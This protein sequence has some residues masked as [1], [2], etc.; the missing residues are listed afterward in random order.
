MPSIAWLVTTTS[1]SRD[2]RLAPAR[3]STRRASGTCAPRHS[4]D[5]T[6][7]CRHA[8]SRDAGDEVVAVARS[9]VSSAHSRSRSDLLAERSRSARSRPAPGAGCSAAPGVLA[10]VE[11]RAR[12]RPSRVAARD[13]VHAEVVVPALE[14][15]DRAARAAGAARA[16]AATSG[17]S[18]VMIWRCSARVAV[19]TTTC[20]S[21]QHRVPHAR[22][23]GSRA[24]CRCRCRPGRA[25]ARPSSIGLARRRRA[26]CV[27]AVAADR[28]RARRPRGRGASSTRRGVGRRGTAVSLGRAGRTPDRVGARGRLGCRGRRAARPRDPRRPGRAAPCRRSV[29]S[30]SVDLARA[31]CTRLTRSPRSYGTTTSTVTPGRGS[32]SAMSA[33]SSSMPSPVCAETTI[34]CTSRERRR[35]IASGVGE[36]GLVEHDDLGHVHRRPG[37]PRSTCRTAAICPSGS[38]C[39]AST[40]CSIRSASATSSSVERN[41]ST[42]WCGR[43]R[44]KP[45]VSASV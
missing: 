39:D 36:V 32:W 45:T 3:G 2:A 18:R 10:E 33:C 11:Q 44:T 19:E 9:S 40:T 29:C 25:G 30:S 8:R 26:I 35:A 15:R 22:A 4:S 20:S 16:P 14:Q 27:L 23:R 41:A 37:C 17:R 13:L 42:S 21:A 5:V 24:T 28:R 6:D 43:A 7:T 38:G 34:E 31:S 12:R 1:A